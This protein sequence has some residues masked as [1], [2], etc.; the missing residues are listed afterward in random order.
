[1]E[2]CVSRWFRGDGVAGRTHQHHHRA[3]KVWRERERGSSF[4]GGFICMI[5][6]LGVNWDLR[7]LNIIS[8]ARS[9]ITRPVDITPPVQA[10]PG[11]DGL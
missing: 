5:A 2:V 3:S 1:M 8:F 7:H 4:I 9:S 6:T 11:I 10:V